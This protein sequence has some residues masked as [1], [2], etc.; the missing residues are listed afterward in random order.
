MRMTTPE[1]PGEP[2]FIETNLSRDEGLPTARA[3]ISAVPQDNLSRRADDS[4][5]PQQAGRRYQSDISILFRAAGMLLRVDNRSSEESA[6][7]RAMAASIPIAVT[8][9]GAIV[10]ARLFLDT[11]NTMVVI[12]IILVVVMGFY[13]GLRVITQP[14]RRKT[15]NA[16]T[17][18]KRKGG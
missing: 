5:E 18:G 8:L 12:L 3:D 4:A 10:F 9:F 2:G 11:M 7:H 15:K 6:T 14:T 16:K 17:R 13:V 1:G